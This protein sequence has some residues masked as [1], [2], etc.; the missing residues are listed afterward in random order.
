MPPRSS[1]YKGTRLS[2]EQRRQAHFRKVWYE[3]D[4]PP[5]WGMPLADKEALREM[6]VMLSLPLSARS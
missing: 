5:L 4:V 1:A 2:V 6:I 3:S